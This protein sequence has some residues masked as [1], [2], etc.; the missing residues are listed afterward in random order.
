MSEVRTKTDVILRT[1]SA[2]SN[3]ICLDRSGRA[4]NSAP[5]LAPMSNQGVQGEGAVKRRHRVKGKFYGPMTD[6]WLQRAE[7]PANLSPVMGVGGPIPS[8]FT[9]KQV[10][11]KN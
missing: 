11:R 5:I 10:G 3:P 1:F 7:G 2:A 9:S 6:G 4:C 8:R